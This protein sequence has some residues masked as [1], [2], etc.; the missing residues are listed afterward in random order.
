MKITVEDPMLIGKQVMLDVWM[1][2]EKSI[3]LY[4]SMG[5]K[6]IGD[7]AFKISLLEGLALD[8]IMQ[9]AAG[10]RT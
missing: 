1:E 7:R 5:F 4:E 8:L 2:N 9:R 6:L 10:W 3:A